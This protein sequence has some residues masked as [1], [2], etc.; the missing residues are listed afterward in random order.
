M[1]AAT[2]QVQLM[3]CH[4]C[5][6]PHHNDELSECVK[7]EARTC[8][9]CYRCFCDDI[10]DVVSDLTLAA[11]YTGQYPELLASLRVTLRGIQKAA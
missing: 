2:Q 10:K 6:T 11:E 4:E 8:R 7:C 5:K 9:A 1:N 3:K